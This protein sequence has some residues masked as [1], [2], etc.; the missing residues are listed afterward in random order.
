MINSI[1]LPTPHEN[2]HICTVG[3]QGLDHRGPEEKRGTRTK[4]LTYL[5]DTPERIVS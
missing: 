1:N 2:R 3:Y 5:L 4:K